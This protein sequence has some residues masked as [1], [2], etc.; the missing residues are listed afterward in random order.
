[1][2][3]AVVDPVTSALW[4]ELVTQRATTVFHSPPWLQV[5]AD[6]YGFAVQ[7]RVVLDHAGRPVA[8]MPYVTVRDFMDLRTT[9]PF[10]D[11]CDPLVDDAAQWQALIDGLLATRQRVD[12][13][14]LHNDVPLDD[15]RFAVVDRALWHGIDVRRDENE[16]WTGL[17][18]SARR[19]L[20]KARSAGVTVEPA[21]DEADLRAF[22]DLHV[23][24]RKYKY[25]LLAQPYRFMRHIW[26]AF[27]AE[28]RGALLLAT[29]DGR[30]VAGVMFLEWKGALYY[31]FNASD[32]AHLDARPNDMVLWEGVRHAQ[33]RGLDRIDFGLTDGDQDGLVRYKRKYATEE[34]TV[35]LLRY[36][37][38]GA[39]SAEDQLARAAL[40][41]VTRLLT[42][43]SVPDAVSAEAGDALYRYFT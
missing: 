37:P 8:G 13:R 35:T 28:D 23:R 24:V 17:S 26:D 32:G 18:S 30:V 34:K 31:K 1:M 20:R 2:T 14:C 33:K 39:P 10:S 36:L 22:F 5:L 7:A 15:D 12:L 42:D 21:H 4:R 16:I 38:P 11:F 9:L 6:T 40:R 27:V 41:D 43:P 25:R 3:V 19:A 29:I